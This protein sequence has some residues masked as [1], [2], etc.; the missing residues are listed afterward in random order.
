M[1]E[2]KHLSQIT[3]RYVRSPEYKN[4]LRVKKYKALL[5]SGKYFF[6]NLFTYIRNYFENR[7]LL[8]NQLKSF[9]REKKTL[10]PANYFIN[11]RIAVYTCIFGEYDFPENPICY[12]NN[13]DYFIITDQIIPNN[14]KWKK[15]DDSLIQEQWNGFSNIEKNRWCKMHPHLLFSNY[16][17][18]VYID[19]NIIPV[20]DF[21]E[22]INRLGEFGI[23]MFWHTNNCVYQ[24]ALYNRYMIRKISTIEL[25]AHINYLKKNGMPEDYGLVT[26]NVIARAH[27]NAVCV[28]L[29]TEWWDEFCSHSKRDMI[30]FPFV[31]WKNKIPIAEIAT[32]GYCVWDDDSVIIKYHNYF[33]N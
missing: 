20:T 1:N 19:G 18:S 22:Y 5:H 12:P 15:Y 16:K 26:C 24:E 11:D 17:Y 8:Q 9:Q 32:L 31:C 13:I 6:K 21:S 33:Y 25:D 27:N 29:M 30:S 3:R 10:S 7:V 4:G 28:K 2:L 23:G 14:L